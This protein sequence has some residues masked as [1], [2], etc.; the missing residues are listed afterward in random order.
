MRIAASLLTLAAVALVTPAHAFDCSKAAS[1]V[2]KAICADPSLKARDDAMAARYAGVKNLS[3]PEEQKMLA[4]SQKAW[5]EGRENQ[6][7]RQSAGDIG[8]CIRGQIG[9]RIA[10]LSV[11]PA[12]GPGTASRLIPV[13]V[14]QPGGKGL[15]AID[16]KYLRFVDPASLGEKALNA[17]VAKIAAASALGAQAEHKGEM[18]LETSS[19][20]TLSYASPKLVSVLH[21]FDSYEGGAHPNGGAANLNIDLVTGKPLTFAKL[22]PAAVDKTL[23]AQCREQIV[24]QKRE[25][26]GAEA[27]DP[28]TDDFLKNDVIARSMGDL[29]RWTLKAAEA[30]VTFDAYEI[31]PYAEGAFACAFLMNDLKALALPNANLP[32]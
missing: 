13:F 21:S 8:L 1:A 32:E 12:S 5:I 24:K 15:F 26:L 18:N 4:R 14:L 9:N 10:E 29:K 19:T 25:R 22:F 30:V 7:G 27:Y 31:G 2:E 6:C 16:G 28:S 17:A 11:K 20:L 23:T 3:T